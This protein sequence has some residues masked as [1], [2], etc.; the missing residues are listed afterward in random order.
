MLRFET[1][2]KGTK[3]YIIYLERLVKSHISIIINLKVGN[4]K[5]EI[6]WSKKVI[7]SKQIRRP[8][9]LLFVFI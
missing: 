1:K 8:H 4:A 3:K 2:I 7:E 9:L 5:T 6:E